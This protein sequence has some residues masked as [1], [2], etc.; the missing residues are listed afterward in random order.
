MGYKVSW[1]IID[2][3]VIRKSSYVLF[4]S[5]PLHSLWAN[6]DL[7]L[8]WNNFYGMKS[9]TPGIFKNFTLYCIFQIKNPIQNHFHFNSCFCCTFS[10]VFCN[11]SIVLHVRKITF[12][13]FIMFRPKKFKSQWWLLIFSSWDACDTAK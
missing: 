5:L 2:I 7:I 10:R 4:K 13:L 9:F 1:F 3:Y 6:L 12:P 11:I 8:I